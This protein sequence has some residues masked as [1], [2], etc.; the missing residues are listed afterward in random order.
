M[1]VLSSGDSG[2]SLKSRVLGLISS[3]LSSRASS[4]VQIV[5]GDG[6][7]P[8]GELVPCDVVECF[9]LIR[10]LRSPT[11]S[12]KEVLIG[13]ALDE[14][15]PSMRQNRFRRLSVM[16]LQSIKVKEDGRN[17]VVNVKRE[18]KKRE[19]KKGWREREEERREMKEGDEGYEENGRGSGVQRNRRGGRWS[20]DKGDEGVERVAKRGGWE[21]E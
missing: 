21:R 15:S 6:D 19:R 1:Y 16:V 3:V 18:R 4:R 11:A 17:N 7:A 12:A 20:G 10:S 8:E 13:K 5:V 2:N 9:V 14:G